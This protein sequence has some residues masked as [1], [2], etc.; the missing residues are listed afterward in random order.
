MAK[1][2]IVSTYSAQPSIAKPNPFL[3]KAINHIVDNQLLTG[4]IESLKVADQGCGKLRHLKMLW[5]YFNTI[6]LIDV[7]FQLNRTQKLFGFQTN[8]KE[9]ISSLKISRKKIVVFSDKDFGA[10]NL[11]LDIVFNLCV[12][13]VEIPK[14]RKAMISAAFNNLKNNGLFIV[15]IPRNDHSILVRCTEKNVYLDGYVFH[16]HGVVTFYK[17]YRDTKS[18]IRTIQSQGFVLK[19]DLSVYRQV[20]LIFRKKEKHNS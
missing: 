7:D 15:I 16:H 20:C 8:I 9:Y 11:N 18:L 12:F 1:F 3:A 4:T 2:E 14:T 19:A 6:Y 17:N 5:E 13:D 10:S